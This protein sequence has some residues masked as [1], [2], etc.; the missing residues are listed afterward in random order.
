MWNDGTNVLIHYGILGQKWG[1]RRFQNPD[2]SYTQEGK[3][4]RGYTSTSLRAYISKKRNEKV[5]K[6]FKEW[7]K[8]ADFKADAIEKGKKANIAKM[9]WERDKQ[10]RDK[11][12]A[13]KGAEKDYKKALSK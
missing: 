6:S 2:G 8:N 1:V 3:K 4:R 5:D 12:R 11:K 10:N 9:E 13:Y 7:N